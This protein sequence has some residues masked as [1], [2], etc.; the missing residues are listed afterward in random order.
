MTGMLD[1]IFCNECRKL[2][3]DNKCQGYIL[4]DLRTPETPAVWRIKDG[5]SFSVRC[6]DLEI[7]K[8]DETD[9]L[10]IVMTGTLDIDN[11][12]MGD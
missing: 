11:L 3:R 4:A 10:K 7:S 1:G 12:K 6:Y 9:K 5:T 2:L 8:S